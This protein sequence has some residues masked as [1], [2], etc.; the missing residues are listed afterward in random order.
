MNSFSKVDVDNINRYGVAFNVAGTFNEK[1]F[2]IKID[3]EFDGR[4]VDSEINKGDYDPMLD[5]ETSDVFFDL[6]CQD[7]RFIDRQNAAYEIWG[8]VLKLGDEE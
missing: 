7:Q 2:D 1:A 5:Y 8:E 6:L 3:C 4:D